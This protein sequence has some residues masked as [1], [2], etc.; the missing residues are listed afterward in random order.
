MKETNDILFTLL[1]MFL[2]MPRYSSKVRLHAVES[3]CRLFSND[4]LL[5]RHIVNI[6]LK[7]SSDYKVVYGSSFFYK[8]V[9]II[10]SGL[11]HY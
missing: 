5:V 7:V 4:L 8:V 11:F 2:L 10:I 3:Y 1:K 9:A 6:K